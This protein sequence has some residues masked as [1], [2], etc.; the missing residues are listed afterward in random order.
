MVSLFSILIVS[1]EWYTATLNPVLPEK[2][3]QSHRSYLMPFQG[4]QVPQSSGNWTLTSLCSEKDFPLNEIAMTMRN[5]NGGIID[6]MRQVVITSLTEENW[7]I[8]H[9]M[10]LKVGDEDYVRQGARIVVDATI[11]PSGY[12]YELVDQFGIIS[13]GV[14][15]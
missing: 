1:I 12:R 9:V 6:P 11:Y 7:A 5:S 3:C 8:Y 2:S 4:Y 13:S 10:Y 15:G 14:L